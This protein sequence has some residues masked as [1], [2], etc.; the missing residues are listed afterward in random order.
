MNSI[1]SFLLH[2]KYRRIW[3]GWKEWTFCN[4]LKIADEY[5]CRKIYLTYYKKLDNNI[6]QF[7]TCSKDF[8]IIYEYVR[9]IKRSFLEKV[10]VYNHIRSFHHIV[11]R[12]AKNNRML[13]YIL[14]NLKAIKPK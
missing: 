2:F 7:L 10:T 13:N 12:H 6:L 8:Y 14:I 4:G 1:N 9:L 5:I 11:E 3:P